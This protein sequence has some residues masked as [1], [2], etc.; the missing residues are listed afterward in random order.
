M[1]ITVSAQTVEQLLQSIS[2]D[3]ADN[4]AGLIGAKEVRENMLAVAASIPYIV[5]SGEWDTAGKQFISNVH[6]RKDAEGTSGGILIVESGIQFNNEIANGELQVHAYPGPGGIDHADLDNL[7]ED[8]H[9][10]YLNVDGR[11]SMT[12]SLG[13]EDN[14][15]RA[16]GSNL[17]S[18]THGIQFEWISANSEVMHVG[19]DTTVKFDKDNST[20]STARSTA[21]A[22]M[23]F[24]SDPVGSAEN[25]NCTIYASY[26]ISRVERLRDDQGNLTNGKF[27]I[28]FKPGLFSSPDSYVA[29]G[30][31]TGRTG[32][33]EGSDFDRV[34]VGIVDRD[35]NS[36]TFYVL[37]QDGSYVNAD[38]NDLIVF[39]NPSG[40]TSA[41]TVTV[42]YE[43]LP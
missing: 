15:I 31:S 18:S 9:P 6:L 39:G 17:S 8:V 22:W 21:Q 40:V 30:S 10:Q 35:A 3:I 14:W 33:T 41:E 4:N 7:A 29:I 16:S 11:R 34:T 36:L 24:S 2:E 12:G 32:T 37:A 43:P 27:R 28:Y 5:A 13:M 26:N 23:T 1:A 42:A 38:V 25:T 20:L 19:S